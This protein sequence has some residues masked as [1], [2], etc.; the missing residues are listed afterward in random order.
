H[1]PGE[2]ARR[3]YE[4]AMKMWEKGFYVRYGADTIQLAPAFTVEENEIDNLV[5]ALADCLSR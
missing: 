5:N 3:P 4:V 1:Y 2:P